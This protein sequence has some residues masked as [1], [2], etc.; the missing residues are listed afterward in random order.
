MAIINQYKGIRI[1]AL[2]IAYDNGMINRHQ[3]E[4]QWLDSLDGVLSADG[5]DQSDLIILDSWCLTLDQE[6]VEDLA[7][8]DLDDQAAVVA[9]CPKPGLCGLFEDIFERPTPMEEC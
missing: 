7:M 8:G 2:L 5:V 9:L 6:Q 4:E 3:S 1:I